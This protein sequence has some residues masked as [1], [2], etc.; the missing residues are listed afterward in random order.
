MLYTRRLGA[1]LSRASLFLSGRTCLLAKDA[2]PEISLL[3]V[4]PS[5]CTTEA[6]KPAKDLKIRDKSNL[7]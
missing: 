7:T 2:T 3:R 6:C 5:E 1:S 4:K